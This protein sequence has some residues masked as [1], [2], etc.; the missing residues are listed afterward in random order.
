MNDN[1][2]NQKTG[3]GLPKTMLYCHLRL[4]ITMSDSSKRVVNDYVSHGS[5]SYTREI[6]MVH[7]KKLEEI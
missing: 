5:P 3:I 1:S 2:N 6:V 7:R 4:Y